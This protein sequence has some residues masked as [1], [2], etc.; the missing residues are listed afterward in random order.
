MLVVIQRVHYVASG[1]HLGLV[2]TYP[3]AKFDP[4]GTCAAPLPFVSSALGNA[5]RPLAF[6]GCTRFVS[7][8]AHCC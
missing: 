5:P 7:P 2:V 6:S 1:Y 8:P 4:K 3:S